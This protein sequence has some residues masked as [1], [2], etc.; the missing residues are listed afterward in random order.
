M[1]RRMGLLGGGGGISPTLN[2][3]SWDV[4]SEVSSAGEAANYWS[5]GDC[6]EIVLDGTVGNLTLSNFTTYAFI[7]GFDHNESIEG[8]GRIHFQIAKTALSVGTDVALCDSSYGSSVSATGYFS[9]NSSPTN[10]GGWK[11]SQMRTNICGTSLSSYSG[12]IIAVIP[13]A[14]RAVLKSVTKYTNNTGKSTAASAVT[15]TTDYF[16]LLSEYEVFGSI[17]YGNSNEASKQAQYAYYSAG[18]SKI[19]YKHSSTS[20]A[21][22][23][24]LRSPYVSSGYA[25]VIVNTGGKVSSYYNADYSI[26][27]AP[28]FCV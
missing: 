18:N 16:F 28:G 14:L 2:N 27:F 11:S 15:E 17:S 20:T 23:W 12:T 9:M 24:R 22:Y 25:F 21:V 19:K 7:I 8:S 13:A 26:G 4:I 6:K 10:S 3:N 1:S 5:V